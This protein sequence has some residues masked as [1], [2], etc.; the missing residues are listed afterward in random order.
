MTEEEFDVTIT[1]KAALRTHDMV[2]SGQE[3]IIRRLTRLFVLQ[4]IALAMLTA[5]GLLV[6][7]GL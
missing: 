1:K 2:M 5:Y 3:R 6:A 4:L 7:G